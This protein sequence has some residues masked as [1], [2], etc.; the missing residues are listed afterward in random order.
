MHPPPQS[1][2]PARCTTQCS[3]GEPGQSGQPTW[4]VDGQGRAFIRGVLSHGPTPGTCRRS[5]EARLHAGGGRR[6]GAGR[7]GAG[8]GSLAG[9]G[10]PAWPLPLLTLASSPARSHRTAP[11]PDPAQTCC[12]A[13]VPPAP[14]PP[15]DTYC[16]VSA[17]SYA[18]M[19]QYANA[20]PAPGGSSGSN[21]GKPA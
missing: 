12:P 4:E 18:H 19:L 1:V 3:I 17:A 21:S 15:A 5:G 13:S 9:G 20:R 16:E 2:E 14:R 7:G 8:R 6:G 10:A 11:L